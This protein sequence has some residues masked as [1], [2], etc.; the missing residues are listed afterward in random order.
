[1]YTARKSYFNPGGDLVENLT[2]GIT[3]PIGEKN[4]T[5][6]CSRVTG[7]R[8]FYAAV[9]TRPVCVVDEEAHDVRSNALVC[10]ET[11]SKDLVDI[12]RVESNRTTSRATRPVVTIHSYAPTV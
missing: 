3:E 7:E 12:R 4:A 1:M 5:E 10:R 8:N 2:S 9:Q 11:F 6:K